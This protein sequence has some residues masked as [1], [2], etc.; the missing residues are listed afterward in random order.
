MH[1]RGKGPLPSPPMSIVDGTHCTLASCHAL[2][3]LPIACPSCRRAFCEQHH[4]PEAHAC[5]VPARMAAST[6]VTSPSR[7]PCSKAGCQRLSLQ[8]RASDTPLAHAAPRCERCQQYFC[9]AHRAPYAHHCTAPAP[10][11]PGQRRAQD[12]LARKAKAKLI[13]AKHFPTRPT[14]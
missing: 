8:V 12:A 1:R 10:P 4:Q 13:L 14:T 9:V 6:S 11:T 5:P 2:T 7:W 3:W